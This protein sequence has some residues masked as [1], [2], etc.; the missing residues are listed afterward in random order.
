MP[1]LLNQNYNVRYAVQTDITCRF[2]VR[3]EGAMKK[4]QYFDVAL[5]VDTE[6]RN[7]K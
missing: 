3:I 1:R 5:F 2:D 4:L 6:L 7:C